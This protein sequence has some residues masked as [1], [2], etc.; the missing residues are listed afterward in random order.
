MVDAGPAS[1]RGTMEQ[2]VLRSVNASLPKAI[3][4][5]TPAA[6]LAGRVDP[7]PWLPSAEIV[8]TR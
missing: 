4:G 7:E 2:V 1:Y 8:A 5:E 6:C 3:D